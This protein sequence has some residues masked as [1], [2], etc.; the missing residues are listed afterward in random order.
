MRRPCVLGALLALLLLAGCGFT[1][2]GA[3]VR[4]AVA[5]GTARAGDT[6]LENA[7]WFLC[8]AAP[9]G[10]VKRRYGADGDMASAYTKLCDRAASAGIVAPVTGPE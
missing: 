10:A 7:E 6:G 9:V 5:E 4:R 3:A 2:Q 1:P 8:E